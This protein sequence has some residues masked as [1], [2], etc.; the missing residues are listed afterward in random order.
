MKRTYF[1]PQVKTNE[2]ELK[3]SIMAGSGS[4]KSLKISGQTS[5]K[6]DLV[7]GC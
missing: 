1:V 3:S 2:I 5:D 6:H 7:Y 4:S